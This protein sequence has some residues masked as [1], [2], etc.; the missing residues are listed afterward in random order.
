MAGENSAT[1]DSIQNGGIPVIQFGITPSR[2]TTYPTD[3]T[4]RNEGQPADAYACGVRFGNVEGSVSDLNTELGSHGSRITALETGMVPKTD[5]ETTL[6]TAGKVADSKATGDAI[7]AVAA[8]TGSDI[9]VSATSEQKLS[10]IAEAV[11]AMFP[12][13]SVYVTTGTVQPPSFFGTWT[14]ITLP[15]K[16]GDANT[17]SRSYETAS[18]SGNVHFWRRIA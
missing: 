14:E 18:G 10:A 9:N 17:G 2:V 8:R 4:M 5:I 1:L 12:V 6:A 7:A 13:G 16:W 11:N 15:L 3:P